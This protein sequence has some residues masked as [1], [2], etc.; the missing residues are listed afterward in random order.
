MSTVI[1]HRMMNDVT[2]MAYYAL[3]VTQQDAC[4]LFHYVWCG[5]DL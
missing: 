4:A 3:N 5:C 1:A 2:T